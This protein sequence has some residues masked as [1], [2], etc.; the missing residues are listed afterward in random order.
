LNNAYDEASSEFINE[1][2]Q[3]LT[4][5]LS[6]KYSK[7]SPSKEDDQARVARFVS[8]F[9]GLSTPFEYDQLVDELVNRTSFTELSVRESLRQ[10][11]AIRMFED[12][13][14][15]AGWWRVGQLYKTGLRMKYV[16]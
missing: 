5:L 8:A 7:G 2:K 6:L 16:R 9:D 14:G 10:M 15:F 4:F 3:E 11:K 13:P 12:R 1:T